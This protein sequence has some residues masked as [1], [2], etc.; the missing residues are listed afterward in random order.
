MDVTPTDVSISFENK[1]KAQVCKKIAGGWSY[2][3]KEICRRE[4]TV[5]DKKVRDEYEVLLFLRKGL[6]STIVS[7][8]QMIS[9]IAVHDLFDDAR[10]QQGENF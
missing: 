6:V 7:S 3:V 4:H 8:M 2:A 9:L 10:H 5:R 1:K